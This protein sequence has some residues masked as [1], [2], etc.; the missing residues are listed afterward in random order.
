MP[1]SYLSKTYESN[2]Y[3]L[4]VDLGLLAKVNQ[5]KQSIFY[6]NAAQEGQ[7]LNQ[8]NNTDILKDSERTYMKDKVN[9]LVQGINDMGGLDYSDMNV[10]N[11]LENYG[12]QIYN[13]PNIITAIQSTKNVR[14]YLKNSE[15]IKNDP[16]LNKYYDPARE[17]YD[18]QFALNPNSI[19]NYKNSAFGKGYDGPTAPAPY[20]GND[21]DLVAAN[22]TKL[23]PNI[24]ESYGPSG[25]PFFIDKT[26]G[27]EVPP[28]RIRAIVDGHID[29]KLADQLNVH[30]AYNYYGL[31]NGT[32]SKEQGASEYTGHAQALL[33]QANSA[34]ST[35]QKDISTEPNNVKRQ[36]LQDRLDDIQTNYLP[37]YQKA[38]DEG[39]K[40]FGKLWDQSPQAAMYTLYK[41][42][43]IDDVTSAY[44]YNQTKH[45]LIVDQQQVYNAK[46]QME[47]LKKGKKLVLGPDG[48]AT[49]EDPAAGPQTP[50]LNN[51]EVNHDAEDAIQKQQVTQQTLLD[52]N[53]AIRQEQSSSL[54]NLINN[55]A[56]VG[57]IPGLI[58]N[59]TTQ[60]ANDPTAQPVVHPELIR[61][62]AMLR[63]DQNL[64][65]DDITAVLNQNKTGDEQY[66][67]FNLDR[68]QDKIMLT[69]VQVEFFQKVKQLMDKG[70]NG[71]DISG[72][73]KNAGEWRDYLTKYSIQQNAIKNNQAL[74]DAAY[75]QVAG[76]KQLTPEEQAA[77]SDYMKNPAAYTS[78]GPGNTYDPI[79]GGTFI[80]N[81]VSRFSGPPAMLR[82]LNKLGGLT[83]VQD[84]M[85]TLLNNTATR[86][87]YYNILLP[88]EN[89]DISDQFPTLKNY[90]LRGID[91]KE[92]GKEDIGV[93]KIDD[94]HPTAIVTDGNDYYV[95][96]NDA[97]KIDSGTGYVKIEPQD[98]AALKIPVLPYPELES[99]VAQHGKLFEPLY[100]N[101]TATGNKFNIQNGFTGPVKIQIDKMTSNGA[102]LNDNVYQ[103][104]IVYN[105]KQYF[106]DAS[107]R[108]T[109]NAAYE[110]VKQLLQN[111]STWTSL[112][113]LI[114][115]LDAA[116]NQ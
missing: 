87:N 72:L 107:K 39:T 47:A 83:N 106:V 33:D 26:T 9:N 80:S 95:A 113:Q 68:P 112:P 23:N 92:T 53:A 14:E 51:L 55:A 75:K 103:A 22:V 110:V 54:I 10:V 56:K 32:Y 108:N 85:N 104:S 67:L 13:D 82:G 77:V 79:S 64:T 1:V 69:P 7:Q 100:V 29:G 43:L 58:D 35:L 70:A 20:L 98:V 15:A 111:N 116:S 42:K 11:T 46:L 6:Q 4:P 28:E 90:I 71:E 25:N 102:S 65:E 12:S 73:V 61:K 34:V 49:F 86:K 96:Y 17:W 16:K 36:Q 105:G 37:Q 18:T 21:F 114:N 30:A 74:I 115:D 63:G 59:S 31:T 91:K 8:L 2:P 60:I 5:Y 66:S 93:K 27:Q 81:N 57:N 19:I 40:Q 52:K 99:V 78:K 89:K 38:V 62:I 88:S 44:S 41:N 45:Q 50:Q 109:A 76:D 48:T 3:V 94:V 84:K 97:S 101:P 24:T